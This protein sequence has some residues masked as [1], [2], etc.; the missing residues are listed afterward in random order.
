MDDW[1][2]FLENMDWASLS[3]LLLRLVAVLLCIMVHEV[4][5]GLA[6]YLLGDPTAKARHRL[7][8]NPIRHIDPL[9]T[10]MMLMVG[11]GWAK[12]VPVDAR[13]FK[14]PRSGMAITALAGPLSNFVLAYVA[15]VF[16]YFFLGIAVTSD[17]PGGWS[18]AAC[19]FCAMTAAL[20]IGLGIFN[21]IPFPPLDGSKVVGA[22]LPEHIYFKILRY[23]FWGMIALMALLWSGWI[24]LPLYAAQQS[25]SRMLTIL[26][27][28]PYQLMV[29]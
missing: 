22:F 20:S 28:W 21:L 7:S 9:G 8:L 12:P 24:D 15:Y 19:E 16:A 3:W 11:F 23:E 17:N 18:I 4:S 27:Q 10:L 14:H 2:R 1:S 13:Y 25:V 6:A 26:A 29:G 5:H